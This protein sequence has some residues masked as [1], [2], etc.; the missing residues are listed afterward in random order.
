MP[1]KIQK[2]FFVFEIIACE[3]VALNCLF[4]AD[5]V[6]HWRWMCQQRDLWFCVSIKETFSN[7]ATFAVINKYC[8][9]AAIQIARVFRPIF[10]VVSLRV[11]WNMAVYTFIYPYFS[12]TV[13]PE[14]HHLR[15]SSFVW[16]CLKFN[17]DF[18]TATNKLRKSLLFL[19]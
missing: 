6:C 16:K 3:L 10:F 2:K 13:F 8:K 7:S 9:G 1:K 4:Y 15:G 12:E 19:R 11:L 14:L 5:N 17:I 18:K